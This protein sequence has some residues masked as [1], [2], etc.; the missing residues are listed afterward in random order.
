MPSTMS[1][2]QTPDCAALETPD[3]VSS[4]PDETPQL[5]EFIAG[6]FSTL[7]GHPHIRY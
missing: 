4:A 5:G 7:G 2:V 3:P 6:D 1:E